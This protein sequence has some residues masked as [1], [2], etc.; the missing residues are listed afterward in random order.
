MERLNQKE[1]SSPDTKKANET[2]TEMS[3]D[4]LR[5]LCLAG[6]E[7]KQAEFETWLTTYQEASLATQGREEKMDLCAEAIENDLE[8]HGITGIEDRLQDG[9]SDTVEKMFSAGIKVWMLTG[10]K[11]ETAI[12][13]SIATGLLEPD[14]PGESGEPEK[15]GNRVI[16]TTSDFEVNGALDPKAVTSYL[17]RVADRCIN[18]GATIVQKGGK[19]SRLLSWAKNIGGP[20]PYIKPL[21][22][23]M[24]IDGRCL[25]LALEPENAMNFVTISRVCRTVVCCRVSPKQKGAVVRLIKAEEKAIT[26]AIGDG[27][28]DCNMIQS[29]DVGIG[30]RGLEGLQAFNVC[31]YGVGQFRFLQYLLF[32]HGRWCYRRIAVL[33][34]YTFYKNIVVVMPQFFLG[35]VSDF[36]GQ[37]LYADL[38]YQAYNVFHSFLPIVLFGIVDQDVS[39]S[40][41]LRYPQLYDMGLT[42]SYLNPKVSAAWLLSGL[43]H[44]SVV[45][46]VPYLSM[47]NGNVTHSDGKA[48]DIWLV[49]ALIYL[50]VTVVVNLMVV[51]ETCYLN[52]VTAFGLVVSSVGWIGG[53]G[54]LSGVVTGAVFMPELHGS[55]Q[56]MFGCPMIWLVMIVSVSLALLPDL[57][58][59][60]IRCIFFPSILHQVQEKAMQE[61]SSKDT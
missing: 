9:V 45:F 25:E 54:I 57:Q 40:T 20:R 15:R 51:L 32:V 11:V 14:S 46:A 44:A 33:A 49:G 43:W 39:R 5:T 50:L 7:L 24:V 13:I 47:S 42:R 4:G 1:K 28:N 12:N 2:L 59:K 26:L 36:S 21:Y 17:Q 37:K 53:H 60:G 18:E 48:N 56:R 41:S 35:F 27:A 16:L 3:L 8:L 38:M 23:G 19:F 29:A 31:D 52:W 6:K 61:G 55:T 58:V 34:N 30:I 10:D 22:E